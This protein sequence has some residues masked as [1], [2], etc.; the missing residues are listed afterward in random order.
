M[1][2]RLGSLSSSTTLWRALADA[3]GS[4]LMNS[5]MRVRAHAYSLSRHVLKLYAHSRTQ[6]CGLD[7]HDCKNPDDVDLFFERFCDAIFEHPWLSSRAT[8]KVLTVERN[9]G[10]E[11]G[12]LAKMFLRRPSTYCVKEKPA[13]HDYGWWTSAQSKNEYTQQMWIKMAEGAIYYLDTMVCTNPWQD[14]LN[15]RERTVKE[16]EE[17]IARFQVV[18]K[19]NKNP[20]QKPSITTSGKV[21]HDGTLQQGVDDDMAMSLAM[22]LYIT[23]RIQTRTIQGVDYN[24]LLGSAGGDARRYRGLKRVSFPGQEARE[25]ADRRQRARVA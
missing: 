8:H 19:A 12:R 2:Y 11:S 10:F 13:S 25:D 14:A 3:T 1:Q 15:R 5:V 21:G 24:K 22:N 23:M 16:F 9:T 17:Q 4:S 18:N 6:I 20:F 7:S